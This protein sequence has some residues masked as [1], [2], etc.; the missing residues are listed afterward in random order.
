M[1]KMRT[2]IGFTFMNKVRTK[3]F[4][5]TTVVLALLVS[6]GLHVPYFIDNL[7]GTTI[8]RQRSASSMPASRSW[9][10]P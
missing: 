9:R 3:A 5:I 2:V 6:V 1:N 4:I 7:P 10:K 8:S